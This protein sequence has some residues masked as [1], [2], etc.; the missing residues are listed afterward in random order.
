MANLFADNHFFSLKLLLKISLLILFTKTYMLTINSEVRQQLVKNNIVKPGLYHFL[1]V[2]F[3]RCF[4]GKR[5]AN[6][7]Q[8]FSKPAALLPSLQNGFCIRDFI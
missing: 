3:Y 2:T 7:F 8:A 1:Q 6:D 4:A 5:S